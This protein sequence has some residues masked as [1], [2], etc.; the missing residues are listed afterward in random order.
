M[1]DVI[2]REP[3][4]SNRSACAH[5]RNFLTVP[6][7]HPERE[8]GSFIVIMRFDL[9]DLRLFLNVH[10]A[11]TI[12]AGAQA[13]HMTLASASER[14]R[15]MEDALG[16]PLLVRD[17]RGART[18]SAGR[19][20]L[21]HARLVLSQV[22]RMHD[23]LGNYGVGLRG[24][25][26]MLCNTS[27]LSEHLPDVIGGFLAEHDGISLD[28]EERTSDEIV[29]AVRNQL[30]DIGMVSDSA[31]TAG[32]ACFVF[33]PD[34]LVLIAARGHP[35]AQ[36]KVVRFADVVDQSWVGL[37]AGGALHDHVTQHARRLGKSLDYRV[38]LRSFESICRV[39]GRGIGLAIVPK[40][41][42]QRHARSSGIRMIVL[43]DTWAQ[44]KLMV[45]VR[46]MDEMPEHVKQLIQYMLA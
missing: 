15:G 12:T 44:R 21:H 46:R 33:R 42:A 5:S 20:L 40:A 38:R 27:A 34:P 28:L 41:V 11:G 31:D 43:S 39:V 7:A 4:L 26:R 29:D 18:T 35:V 14:I 45:C 24:H 17:R 22:Q 32:L 19:A 36:S 9:T 1:L 8:Y 25:V 16:V 6:Q 37:G 23:E 10:E 13:S 3:V 30:C 2:D